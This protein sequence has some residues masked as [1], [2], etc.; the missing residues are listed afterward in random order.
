VGKHHNLPEIDVMTN[1]AHMSAAAGKY[2]G[3]DRFEARARVVSDLEALGLLERIEEIK[4]AVGVCDR[5]KSEVEPRISTQWFMK[6]KPLAEPALHAVFEELI[7]V[8][9][10]NQRVILI[11]WLQNIRDWC[12][13]RQLWWGHR[14][15]IW[16]CQECKAMI[17]A[18]NSDVELFEGH[19]RPPGVPAQCRKCGSANLEQDKDVLDPWFSS[20]L[21]P[22][23]T[24]GWPDDTEDLRQFYPTQLLISGYDILFFWDARMVMLGLHLTSGATAAERI[25]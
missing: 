6:M 13:S 12:I 19:A 24:L 7:G 2:A 5:C 14:I 4:H 15:P 8:V 11:N 23:S 25:P 21:W 20:G 22:F 10:D 9:P 1:D 3:L 16:H 17:P 18:R